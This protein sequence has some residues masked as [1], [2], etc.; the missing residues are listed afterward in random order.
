MILNFKLSFKKREQLKK[1]EG[2]ITETE[3]WACSFED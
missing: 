2:R 1:R 3:K